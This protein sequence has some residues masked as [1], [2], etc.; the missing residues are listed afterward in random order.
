MNISGSPAIALPLYQREDL[1]SA[2]PVSV[3]VIGQPA[4]EA[5]LLAL[6]AQL[7]AAQPWADRRAAL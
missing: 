7:E 1:G 5:D 4:G 6:A 3:Q 2:L